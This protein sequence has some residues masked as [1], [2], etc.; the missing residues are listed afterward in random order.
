M[1]KA[2][3]TAPCG[4]DCFNCLTYEGNIIAEWKKHLSESLNIPMDEVA[5]KGCRAEQGK[6]KFLPKDQCETWN[7]IQGKGVDFCHECDDF[8]CVLLMPSQQG[9]PFAHN[10]KLYNLCRMK[11][12]GID[13]WIEEAE[14]V[15]RR[16]FEGRFEV[17]SGPILD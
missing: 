8:P 15:R 1:D 4:T 5:C 3:L 9:A 12:V 11:R 17:G 16:Y 10:L 7:C 2:F 14:A 6:C 13:K